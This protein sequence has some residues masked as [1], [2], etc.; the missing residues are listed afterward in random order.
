MEQR[1]LRRTPARCSLSPAPCQP[2]RQASVSPAHQRQ[3]LCCV[4]R[5]CHVAAAFQ[6]PPPQEQQA[7][8]VAPAGRKLGRFSPKVVVM[9]LHIACV[10]CCRMAFVEAL[11]AQPGSDGVSA[12]ISAMDSVLQND[13]RLGMVNFRYE[14]R[15]C[16]VC[17]AR[18]RVQHCVIITIAGAATRSPWQSHFSGQVAWSES[19]LLLIALFPTGRGRGGHADHP[20]ADRGAAG[21]GDRPVDG[22]LCGNR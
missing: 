20:A 13:I 5:H 12:C 1:A 11:H 16:T 17:C 7:T 14:V 9:L 10:S 8:D 4:R 22:H 3:Q 15:T 6:T 18:C 2:R 21:A 19:D